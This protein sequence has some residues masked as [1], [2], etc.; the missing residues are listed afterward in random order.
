MDIC[1][2]AV[3]TCV[4]PLFEVID[5]EWI[6]NYEPKNKLPVTEYLKLQGRFKHLFKPENT[7]LL[8]R[9]QDDVDQ[10]WEELKLRAG[11]L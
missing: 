4:W 11:A 2:A 10:R 1:K 7:E 8:A 9:I 3:E 6:L 5:G